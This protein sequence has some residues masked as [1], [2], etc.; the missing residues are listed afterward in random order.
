[1]V[2]FAVEEMEGAKRLV[3]MRLLVVIVWSICSRVCVW[4]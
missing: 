1:M 3:Q 2:H 4:V